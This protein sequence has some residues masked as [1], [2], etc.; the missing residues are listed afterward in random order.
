MS[1]VV[2]VTGGLVRGSSR[3]GVRSFLG[4]PYAGPAVGADRYRAPQPVVPWDGE[5]DATH[6]GPTASQS[7]YPPPMDAV[8]PSSV[9]A[10]DDYL[11]VNVWAPIDGDS[12]PVMVWIHGGAFV[13]G[14]NSLPAYDGSA[15]ARDGVVLVGINYRLGVPGFGALEGAPTNLGIR[16]QI[17]ALEWVRDNVVAFGGNPDDVTV[18]G[19]SAGAMSVATL[20]ACPAA[21]GLFHRAVV[22]SGGASAVCSLEDARRVS[23]E[24]AAQLGVPATAA[25][26]AA[27]DPDAVTAA[28]SAV[29]LAIQA[30][31]D[32]QR[33]G[34]SVLSGGLGIMSLFPVVDGDLVPD[35]PLARIADG[36][37]AGVPLLVGTTSEEFRLFLV[38]TGLACAVTPA[39]LGFLAARYGWPPQAIDAYAANRPDGSPGDVACAILTDAGFRVPAARL[40]AAHHA[41]GGTVHAY[42]FAWP[43]DVGGLGACHGL[44]LPFV[45][46]T[47]GPGTP[48]AGTAAPQHLAREMHR[49]W[50][51]FASEG[52]PGW[53]AWS[54]DDQAVMTFDVSSRVVRG[55]RRDELDL[56]G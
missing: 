2:R 23:A 14:T 37:A 6:P 35:V 55:P 5:R 3:D 12:R 29:G 26:F 9:A 30:D 20:M 4:I 21:R 39:A 56:W 42:E 28:Q 45:F 43:T 48:M 46:D 47:L 40:A 15:F 53:Q 10:G 25:A 32:P 27:I 16:D 41:A 31:P 49:A 44:E 11:N 19:E 50:V 33:W 7:A 24:L 36:A 1:P 22:Q 51:R 54:P 52:S 13:R 8:L 17:T 34:P 18:F 38:P